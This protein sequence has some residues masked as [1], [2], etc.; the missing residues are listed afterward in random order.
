[1][2]KKLIAVD[3]D[4]G[5][6]REVSRVYGFRPVPVFDVSQTDGEPLPQAP[7]ID[8]DPDD[9]GPAPE[10]MVESLTGLIE[11]D[12]FRIRRGDTGK[13]NGWTDFATSEVVIS[14]AATARQ[15]ARTLAH[16][17]AHIALGHG[18]RAAEYHTG[19]GGKRP[20]F[21]VAA[22]S[23][24]FVIGRWYGLRGGQDNFA[25]ID[26]WARGDKERVRATATEVV[27]GARKIIDRLEAAGS[28]LAQN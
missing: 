1:M 4:S 5:A 3:A 23:I 16:E 13:A 15:A 20:D 7:L 14:Q 18:E 17:A 8:G 6:E 11:A 9:D 24:S 28:A 22:D 2:T 27:A 25:Y 19:A 26:S 10:G 12:G 21:E